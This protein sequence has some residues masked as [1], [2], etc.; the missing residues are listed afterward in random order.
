MLNSKN[1]L[2]K[3]FK[4]GIK[5]SINLLENTSVTLLILNGFNFGK[6]MQW[7]NMELL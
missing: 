6:H 2:F 3:T 7:L 1:N 5:S 4:H